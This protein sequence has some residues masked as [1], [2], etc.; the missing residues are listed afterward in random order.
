MAYTSRPLTFPE[1]RDFHMLFDVVPK[2]TRGVP[3]VFEDYNMRTGRR[4][5]E[6]IYIG[7][8][9]SVSPG[10]QSLYVRPEPV[11]IHDIK[12]NMLAA[13]VNDAITFEI[14]VRDFHDGLV[15]AKNSAIIGSRWLALIDPLTIPDFV[16]PR[17]LSALRYAAA[18][19][20]FRKRADAYEVAADALEEEDEE[21]KAKMARSEADELRRAEKSRGRRKIR[22]KRRP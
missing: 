12:Q 10:F 6:T 2:G 16:S 18:Q 3:W 14:V 11:V 9:L 15:V 19:R 7:P 21:E 8:Y 1:T 13:G 5:L 20:V 17:A 22:R 4:R